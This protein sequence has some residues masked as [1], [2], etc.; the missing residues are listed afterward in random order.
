M[1]LKKDLKKTSLLCI[2]TNKV[3]VMTS[4]PTSWD[5]FFENSLKLSNDF[6]MKRDLSPPQQRN[7]F[8]HKI[9]LYD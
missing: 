7:D 2:K 5:D 9:I 4:K 3:I 8:F 6:C 1:L